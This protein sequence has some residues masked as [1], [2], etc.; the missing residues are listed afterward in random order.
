MPTVVSV[1]RDY[2]DDIKFKFNL[3]DNE[4]EQVLNGKTVITSINLRNQPET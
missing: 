4:L 1:L 3:A 2:V